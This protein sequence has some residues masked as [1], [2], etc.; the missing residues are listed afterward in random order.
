VE[1]SAVKGAALTNG[2]EYESAWN[3]PVIGQLGVSL[4]LY[5]PPRLKVT[6]AVIE[7]SVIA[8]T[9]DSGSTGGA[10]M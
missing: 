9:Y 2:S 5:S 8:N 4:E 1:L 3:S 6:K 7:E 10:E